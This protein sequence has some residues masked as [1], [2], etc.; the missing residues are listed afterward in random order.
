MATE[1]RKACKALRRKTC[2]GYKGRRYD[3]GLKLT[4]KEV[5]ISVK[6]VHQ[7]K[8][9]LSI[10]NESVYIARDNSRL[11]AALPLKMKVSCNDETQTVQI[12]ST[13]MQISRCGAYERVKEY[14]H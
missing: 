4:G 5:A 10:N 11:N 12:G 7:K 1:T 13:K 14:L 3:C 2:R 6:G 8:G 9:W